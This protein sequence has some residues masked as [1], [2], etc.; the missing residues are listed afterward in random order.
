MPYKCFLIQPSK[1][2]TVEVS[3]HG[4]AGCLKGYMG[5]HFFEAELF[6]GEQN[7]AEKFFALG[8][9][10]RQFD[11]VCRHC[12]E[13]R[14]GLVSTSGCV[15]SMWE[16]SDTGETKRRIDEFPAGA[17]W[18][19]DWYKSDERKDAA[20]RH[21]YDWDWDNQFEP[22]LIVKTPGGDWNIDSRCS[23]CTMPADKTHRCWVRH[24]NVPEITVD[25]NGHTCAAGA[26]SILCGNYHGF[27]RNGYLTDGC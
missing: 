1:V 18:F 27:L 19:A 10:S 13:K 26:G 25:K 20:G 14:A 22:P 16:R 24:G 7:E 3:L 17:M 2:W 21:L 6:R 12:A 11:G 5:S 4:I 15:G 9:V 8:T 23:N